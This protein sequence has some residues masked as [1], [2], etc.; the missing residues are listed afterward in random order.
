MASDMQVKGV[1]TD[2]SLSINLTTAD[3]IIT[4]GSIVYMFFQISGAAD[5]DAAWNILKIDQTDPNNITKKWAG[6]SL[7]YS[8]KAE[9]YLTVIY[10]NKNL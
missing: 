7:S 8:T 5:S 1:Y 9:D 6:G 4:S 3:K 10:S 2:D